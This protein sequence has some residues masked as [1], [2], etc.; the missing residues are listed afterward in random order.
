MRGSRTGIVAMIWNYKFQFTPLHERQP[1]S[2]RLSLIG[3][4]FQFTPLHER[5][6]AVR[7]QGEAR[8]LFQF[9]PLHE[10]QRMSTDLWKI[11]GLFQFTP[12][13]ERQHT[14]CSASFKSE[15]FNSRLY[16][17]GSCKN[18]QFFQ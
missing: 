12:L 2:F 11:Y 8:P 15:Y 6:R 5:Q 1:H 10:R 9:T 3:S 18:T 13:H 17:R 4:V 7:R 16:M 14:V